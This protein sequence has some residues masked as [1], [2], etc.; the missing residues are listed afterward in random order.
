MLK[1]KNQRDIMLLAYDISEEIN[2]LFHRKPEER[3]A[4][5]S[6]K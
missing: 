6:T 2:S 1:K 5:L 4:S 3:R